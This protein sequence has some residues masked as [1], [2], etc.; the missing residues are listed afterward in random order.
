MTAFAMRSGSAQPH[1][2]AHKQAVVISSSGDGSAARY[3]GTTA[4]VQATRVTSSTAPA[5]HPVPAALPPAAELAAD[6][7]PTTALDAY[8][9]AAAI[10]TRTDPACGI[11]WP[12]LAAIG[13]V[14][15]DHGRSGGAVLYATGVSAPQIIGIPLDGHG[16]A[17]VRDT[18][19]GRYDHDTVYDHAVGPMQFIPS[20]WALYG[21]DGNGDRLAD[22]FNIYDA[23]K[24]AAA[25]LCAVSGKLST[26]AGQLAALHAYNDS[27]A[28]ATLVLGT[29]AIYA[30]GTPYVVPTKPA[31]PVSTPPV[32]LPPA[33]PGPPLGLGDGSS[34]PV[35][36]T[37]APSGTS[38]TTSGSPP[39][40]LPVPTVTSSPPV[41]SSPPSPTPDTS[42]GSPSPTM[43][44]TTASSSAP[45]SPPTSSAVPSATP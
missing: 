37:P 22:P 34:H 40:S 3:G 45:S 39:S 35:T 32:H 23:T 38:V 33:D 43:P 15:S 18:D 26:Y 4:Q 29:E 20:T 5:A 10:E 28:Y 6:G 31:G 24:A 30:T 13:R 44:A 7:I 9:R 14:E 27:D 19:R 8:R 42:A 1:A 25:Y 41:V 21:T 12:L 11:A 36:S 2:A 16:T 17:L